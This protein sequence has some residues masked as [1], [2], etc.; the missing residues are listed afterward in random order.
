MAPLEE[1]NRPLAGCLVLL[2]DDADPIRSL[3]T[4]V[5]SRA[6]AAVL[7]A[8]DGQEALAAF[9]E[10]RR[11]SRRLDAAVVDFDMPGLRGDEVAAALRSAGFRA[12]IVGYTART[13]ME[14]VPDLFAAAGCDAF[15]D[16]AHEVRELT[17]TVIG[18][19]GR[20]WAQ[21]DRD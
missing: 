7:P 8:A 21:R 16:K 17:S 10:C 15:V 13:E 6:G 1:S 19:C 5:L 14:G 9:E 4:T 12:A 20:R 3:Y 2:A 11:A 18:V